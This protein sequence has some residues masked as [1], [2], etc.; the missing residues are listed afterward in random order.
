MQVNRPANITAEP[1][2]GQFLEYELWVPQSREKVFPFF[3]NARNLEAITPPW[4]RFDVLTIDP[5]EMRCGT[6]IDYRLKVRGIPLRWR[7]EITVWEPP[8]RFVD[9]Q[10]RG[11][12]RLWRHEHRFE[13]K[14]GGTLLIDKIHFRVF[15]GRL[16]ERFFVRP[17]VEKIFAFRRQKLTELFC[18]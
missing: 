6:L 18:R 5:I 1:A 16:V 3:A 13:E 4:L 10:L 17:D 9:T 12:Y 14:D 2:R 15:G 8:L 7:S 11:P